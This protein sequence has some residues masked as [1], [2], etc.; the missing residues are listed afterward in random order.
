[1]GCYKS[2]KVHA[3]QVQ[4]YKI[5]FT[6]KKT[7]LFTCTCQN[8]LYICKSTVYIKSLFLAQSQFLH[9]CITILTLDIQV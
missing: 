7:P 5:T 8:V 3:E 4:F 6:C 2:V 1:M 9:D